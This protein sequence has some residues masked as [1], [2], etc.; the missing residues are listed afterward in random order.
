MKPALMLAAC[1]AL[2]AGCRNPDGS[3]DGGAVQSSG[4][5]LSGPAP[6]VTGTVLDARTGKPIPGALVRG[7]NGVET[8]SDARGRFVLRGLALGVSGELVGTTE[9]GL[10]GRNRLRVLEGGPLEVVLHLR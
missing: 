2:L 3:E 9:S 1:A 8:K 10:S 7:P 5:G 4:P 6:V